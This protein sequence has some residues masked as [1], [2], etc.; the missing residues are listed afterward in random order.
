MGL[1][2]LEL[3]TSR[4]SDMSRALV[5]AGE[6]WN[7]GVFT[8][9]ALVGARQRWPAMIQVVIQ[10]SRHASCRLEAY[11]LDFIRMPAPLGELVVG[12][13]TTPEP[14]GPTP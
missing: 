11:H 6:R 13:Q 1:G 12:L 2:R 14:R 9:S 5:G 10:V 8:V 7:Q 4:L 3:P